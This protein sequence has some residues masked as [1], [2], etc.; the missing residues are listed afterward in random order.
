[1]INTFLLK[2]IQNEII[3]LYEEPAIKQIGQFLYLG[4]FES[5]YGYFLWF[6]KNR[7]H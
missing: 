1:M 2:I 3:L 4:I 6:N 5:Y 7:K